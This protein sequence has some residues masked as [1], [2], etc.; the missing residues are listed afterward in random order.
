MQ[1]VLRLCTKRAGMFWGSGQIA[2]HKCGHVVLR[3]LFSPCT[4]KRRHNKVVQAVEVT[5]N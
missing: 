5:D 4:L 3:L 2:V 1:T